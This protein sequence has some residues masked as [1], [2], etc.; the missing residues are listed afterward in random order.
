MMSDNLR[1]AEASRELWW[2]QQMFEMQ[3]SHLE[4]FREGVEADKC[5]WYQWAKS[6]WIFEM[7]FECSGALGW[8][9]LGWVTSVAA[10][11]TTLWFVHCV[12]RRLSGK[13]IHNEVMHCYSLRM[14][15]WFPSRKLA[16]FLTSN[17]NPINL[18][19]S[20]DLGSSCYFIFLFYAVNKSFLPMIS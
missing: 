13:H 14:I 1:I 10:W 5:F 15:W 6:I 9:Y 17:I 7:H 16:I 18:T 20:D 11:H 19:H 8:N 12:C 3:L 4:P 2:L